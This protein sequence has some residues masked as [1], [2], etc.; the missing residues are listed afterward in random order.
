MATCRFPRLLITCTLIALLLSACAGSSNDQP[1]GTNQNANPPIFATP[2]QRTLLIWHALDSADRGALEQI[3]LSFEVTYP[4]ID[5]QLEYH[6]PAALLADFQEA[7]LGGAGPDLLLG[8]PTWIPDLVR[9]GVIEPYAAS[10]TF[11]LGDSMSQPLIHSGTF[12]GVAYG[13]PFTVDL[14][15]MYYNR[16]IVQTPPISYAELKELASEVGLVVSPDF[17]ATSGLYFASGGDLFDDTGHSL[18]TAPALQTYLTKIADLAAN[19]GVIFATSVDDFQS[20]NAN[21]LIGSSALYAD[22]HAA[23]QGDLGVARWPAVETTPWHALV[24]AH[25]MAILSLNATAES[26]DAAQTFLLFLMKSN[27]Q[28]H[29]FDQTHRAVVN[30]TE[31]ADSTL[32]AAWRATLDAAIPVPLTSTF[33]TIVLPALNAAVYRVALQHEDPPSVASATIAELQNALGNNP[34]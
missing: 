33:A 12:G 26:V 18:I 28:Q 22:L 29:W 14:P 6:A 19:P 34:P 4:S 20:R 30:P 8:E 17:A 16:Q 32:A 21:L 1:S 13:I 25:P 23:L 3:R 24:A 2:L 15:T 9:A 7:V 27:T 11:V 5:V 10:F 31:L